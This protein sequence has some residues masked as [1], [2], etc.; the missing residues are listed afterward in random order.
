MDKIL[1]P[2]RLLEAAGINNFKINYKV[3]MIYLEG[4]EFA[5]LI[6]SIPEPVIFQYKKLFVMQYKGWRIVQ[7][8]KL[9]A[10]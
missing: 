6:K 7:L 4:K 1:D 9:T 2:V 8:H 5:K 10:K 3:R